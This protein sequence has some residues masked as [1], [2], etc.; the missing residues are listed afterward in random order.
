[1]NRREAQE[2]LRIE[3]LR[4]IPGVMSAKDR[5]DVAGAAQLIED[6][7]ISATKLG[8]NDAIAWSTLFSATLHWSMEL[9]QETA[10]GRDV[11]VD[12]LV[13]GMALNVASWVSEEHGV[14]GF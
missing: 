13:R 8:I 14:G 9:A 10:A 6:F 12:E 11:T 5:D 2:R 4:V 1:M 7:R 3:A